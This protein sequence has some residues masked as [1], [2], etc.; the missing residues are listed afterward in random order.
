ME[1]IDNGF[2]DIF[3]KL[4]DPRRERR[5]LHPMPEILLLT[6]C[7]V[8]CGAESWIDI[9]D[10]GYAKL[11]FLRRYLPYENGIPSDD[12]FRRF[13]RA[14][15]TQH[16]Q[17]LFVEWIRAWLSPDVAEKVIAIDGKT[18]RGSRNGSHSA[19]HMVSAFAS[20]AGIV[21]GQVKTQEKSNEITAIP[22]LLDWIDIRGA[23]VTIDAMGCQKTIT[24]KI[25]DKGGDYLISLKGNQGNLHTDVKMN[26]EKPTVAAFF[27]MASIESEA[28][29]GHGRIEIRRC[30]VSTD[31]D[32]I[33]ARHPEWAELNS[34]VAVESERHI[35]ENVS[36]ET[37][38]FI[39]SS[40]STPER[41]MSAV[42]QHWGIENQLHWVLDVSFGEDSSR[43]R[44]DNA[45]TN[46][47]IIRHAALNMMRTVKKTNIAYNRKSIRL[48]RK[49]AGWRDDVL[50][51]I[52]TQVF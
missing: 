11:H 6:L 7:S 50:A 2:L 14:I 3:G 10:F 38:Y 43:I 22:E 48:M 33:R 12:T 26:F 28:E 40:T 17:Q 34:V 23:I 5:K 39:S 16:F 29:K 13:F 19:I 35:G 52:L 30:K 47:A 37:R 45:P 8:I 42:R 15:D 4:E 1:E 9:E 25:V 49:S 27:Q 24:Q 51:E 31:I 41:L 46:M 21:L 18:L 20:E 32:W 44:K 36:I